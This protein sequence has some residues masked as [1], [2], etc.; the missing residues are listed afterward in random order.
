MIVDVAFN[1]KP[2]ASQQTGKEGMVANHIAV[3]VIGR[4]D[5]DIAVLGLV[6]INSAFSGYNEREPYGQQKRFWI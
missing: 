1:D 3:A 6:G 2:S 5:P 4:G